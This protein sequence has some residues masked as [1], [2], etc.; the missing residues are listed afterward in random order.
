M[1]REQ[2]ARHTVDRAIRAA[3]R[4][5]EVRPATRAEIR[6]ARVGRMKIYDRLDTLHVT[7]IESLSSAAPQRWPLQVARASLAALRANDE[8][9][10]RELETHAPEEERA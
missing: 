5:G 7:V 1:G 4:A 3:G 2:R 10:Y 9:M 6:H 8:A